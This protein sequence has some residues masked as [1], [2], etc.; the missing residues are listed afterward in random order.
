MRLWAGLWAFL[1]LMQLLMARFFEIN[2]DEY[3]LFDYTNR[4]HAGEIQNPL[5][6]IAMWGFGFL[7]REGNVLDLIIQARL[8]MLVFTAISTALIF[9]IARRFFSGPAALF[10]VCC[11]LS[12]TFIFRNIGT[13][14]VDGIITAIGLGAIYC[15]SAPQPSRRLL[16]LGGFLLALAAMVS[17]KA[18]FFVPIIAIFLLVRWWDH[19]WARRYFIDGLW[20]FICSLTAWAALYAINSAMI[21]AP[22]GG[23][24]GDYMQ[25]VSKLS[26]SRLFAKGPVFLESVLQNIWF[27]LLLIFSIAVI[28]RSA[29]P[30]AEKI[31]L[32]GFLTPLIAL[33]IYEYANVYFYAF[34]FSPPAIL[35]AAFYDKVLA[36]A[37]VRW[38]IIAAAFAL[39]VSS[40]VAVR[41]LQ[42]DQNYHRQ[43]HQ[44][45]D[46]IFPEPA[47]YLDWCA[48]MGQHRRISIPGVFLNDE[49]LVSMRGYLQRGE[50]VMPGVMAKYQPKFIIANTVGLEL[51]DKFPHII[52][53]PLLAADKMA[54]AENY[55][56]VWGPIHLPGKTVP[57]GHSEPKILIAG[58]YTVS[59]ADLSIDGQ[60]YASGDHVDLR[61]QTYSVQASGDA[62]LIWTHEAALPP[63][64]PNERKIFRG[65]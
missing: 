59:G 15:A 34:L 64:P 4:F 43:T 62:Q 42:Q 63:A 57:A 11:F 14:R 49:T 56:H 65:F 45:I 5:Q 29:R 2:W 61:Q 24:S 27:W 3:Y 51:E 50:P 38:M 53:R 54:L 7:T 22:D 9:L 16:T 10:S 28:A 12:Y 52:Q 44:L 30:R 31:V 20:M 17:M 19:G 48:M 26:F 18:V 23:A 55:L 25:S 35:L 37:P 33:I 1:M 58:T 40:S 32:L 47:P 39:L 13:Y 21:G 36:S 41:S 46:Q 6:T 8:V 60:S